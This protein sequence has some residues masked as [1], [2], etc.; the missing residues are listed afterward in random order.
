MPSAPSHAD[1]A[2]RDPP[3]ARPPAT[4]PPTVP[5]A[6]ALKDVEPRSA[7]GRGGAIAGVAGNGQGELFVALVGRAHRRPRRCH[8]DRPAAHG[9]LGVNARRALG[10]AFVPEERL[11]HG[12]VPGFTLSQ[13]VVLTRHSGEDGL[14]AGAMVDQPGATQLTRARSR[15]STTSG[16]ASPIRKRARCRAAT[17]RNSSWAA[18]STASPAC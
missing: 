6:V 12:A 14:A 5:S 16:R 13:N 8:R 4:C 2:G 7:G 1:T 9:G 3:R 17:C 18:N 15:A 11:G 10:A